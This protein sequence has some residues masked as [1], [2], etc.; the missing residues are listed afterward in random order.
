[1]SVTSTA[2]IA[3][4]PV[5]RLRLCAVDRAAGAE[6]RLGID[7]SKVLF[8]LLGRPIAMWSTDALDTNGDTIALVL[9]PVGPPLVE[10][11]LRA[12]FGDRLRVVIQ[13]TRPG[14]ARCPPREA[15]SGRRAHSR[16]LG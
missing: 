11:V 5:D 13:Y 8:P 2:A 6:S 1:M 3:P 16:W 4:G 14:C 15:R 7:F 9:S 10:P 12:R